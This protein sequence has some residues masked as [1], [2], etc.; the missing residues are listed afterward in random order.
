MTL[1]PKTKF[2]SLTESYVTF[3]SY[4]LDT[5]QVEVECFIWVLSLTNLPAICKFLFNFLSICSFEITYFK[6]IRDRNRQ[7]NFECI[8]IVHNFDLKL[9]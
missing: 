6:C 2:N 8:Y 5:L 3:G 4:L 9:T 7:L 1:R